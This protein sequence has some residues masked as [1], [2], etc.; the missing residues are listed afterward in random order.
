MENLDAAP[1]MNATPA[2]LSSTRR[3]CMTD[4]ALGQSLDLLRLGLERRVAEH[5]LDAP[6]DTLGEIVALIEHTQRIRQSHPGLGI[7]HA[8]VARLGFIGI[9]SLVPSTEVGEVE[10]GTR[11]L[12]KAWG[13][14]YALEGGIALCEHAFTT[15]GLP[16]LIGLCTPE[17][18]SVPPLL[19]RLG[20]EADGVTTQYGRS[21]VRHRLRREHWSGPRSR[22]RQ[23]TEE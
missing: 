22:R 2:A 4:L 14:G 5:I 1:C 19:E 11:L 7:W 13:R 10:I 12:T 9:F 8:Q 3:M 18:R 17:N 15:L 16:S 6:L 20:F 21:A 23:D